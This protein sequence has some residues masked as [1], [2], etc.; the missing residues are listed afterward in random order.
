M[1]TQTDD[2]T[3]LYALLAQSIPCCHPK[4]DAPAQVR[5][6]LHLPQNRNRDNGCSTRT[7][8]YCTPC[9]EGLQQRIAEAL[10][11]ACWCGRTMA[12]LSDVVLWV[13][14]L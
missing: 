7:V 2:R 14:A 11:R 1:S 6:R 9:I 4:C 10:P 12:Q 3:D 13:K 8:F 5:A